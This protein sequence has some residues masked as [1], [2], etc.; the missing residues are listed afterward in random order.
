M[1]IHRR[2]F[3][4]N[5]SARG[6]EL[7][8]DILGAV[9]IVLIQLLL[10]RTHYRTVEYQDNRGKLGDTLQVYHDTFPKLDLSIPQ[11]PFLQLDLFHKPLH[12]D[13]PDLAFFRSF[14]QRFHRS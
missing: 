7:R 11:D 1:T 9:I 2:N 12:I 10:R 8:D 13:P 3:Q 14:P 6:W 5:K 4:V